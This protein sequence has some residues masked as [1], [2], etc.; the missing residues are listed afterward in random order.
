MQTVTLDEAQRHLS[1]LVRDL[2]RKGDLI[3]TDAH[4]PVAKLS[5]VIAPFSLR[6]LK[7][8]SVGTVLRS[9]P[10]P[11]DDTLVEMLDAGR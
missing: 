3:I 2:A 5:H 10:S 7:P 11:E 4:K 6:N 9:F 8:K 1:E